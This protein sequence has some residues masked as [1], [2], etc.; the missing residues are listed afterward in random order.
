MNHLALVLT[1]ASA[2]QA[3]VPPSNVEADTTSIVVSLGGLDL[4]TAT[5]RWKLQQRIDRA[6]RSAC[7]YPGHRGL[8]GQEGS[9]LCERKAR[10]DAQ[11]SV[12]AALKSQEQLAQASIQPGSHERS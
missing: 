1:F 6:I 10:A 2:F 9:D 11:Q 3:S 4:H 7:R 5:G 12:E 8:E